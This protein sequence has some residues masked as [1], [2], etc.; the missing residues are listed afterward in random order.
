MSQHSSHVSTPAIDLTSRNSASLVDSALHSKAI[1]LASTTLETCAAAGVGNPTVALS[2]VHLLTTLLYQSMRWDPAAPRDPGADRLVISDAAFAPLVYAACADLGVPA[3]VDGAWRPLGA[4]DLG[5]FGAAEG[6]LPTTPASGTLALIEHSVGAPGAGLSIAAGM[7]L[8]ARLDASDRRV[9]CLVSE[10]ELR[11]GQLHEALAH[12]VEEKLAALVPIFVVGAASPSDKAA[13]IDGPDALVRRLGALGFHAVA[14]DG[15]HPAQIRDALALVGGKGPQP[16]AIVARC[17]RGWGAK[18]IQG[19]A[20]SGRV[21][22]GDR[23]KAALDELRGMRVGLTRSFAGELAKP[24]ARQRAAAVARP[25]VSSAIAAVPDFARA[26][27]EADMLAVYQSGKLAPTK[28]HALALRSLGRAHAG[29][30]LLEA[31]PRTSGVGELFA[32]DRALASRHI[33][34]RR[35]T[36]HMVSLAEGLAASGRVPFVSASARSL[37]RA[38]ESIECAVRAGSG[39]KLVATTPGLGGIAEGSASTSVTDAAFF[40]ALSSLRDDA[41]NPGAYLL[42]PADAFAAYA[43]TLAAAE[44]DGVTALRLPAG[45]Q[46]FLYNAETVFNLGRFEVLCE[47]RDLLI[48]TAGAMVHE[49]NRALDDLDRAGIDATIVDLYSIPFDEEALLDL[50]NRN[51]GRILVVEDNAGGALA[52]AVAEACAAAGDAFTIESMCV[53]AVPQSARNFGEALKVAKLS[54][55]DIVARASRLVGVS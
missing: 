5:S 39:V 50:A 38:H 45:E 12:A 37:A 9:F 55:A 46:E 17:V 43:L 23:L 48:V 14:I 34:C 22:T 33:D 11:E 52:G 44:H 7:A 19:G 1:A 24:A 54:A 25:S 42:Q 8:G 29:V 20:W 35:A 36:E 4:A 3:L 51:D 30:S 27:R 2:A 6:P 26:M 15:H 40:R 49:V 18:S 10:S 13:A 21:P 16:I 41:G 28:A 47:G 31:D 32:A 53:H